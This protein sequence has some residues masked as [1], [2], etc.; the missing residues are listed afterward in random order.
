MPPLA[1][2]DSEL[3]AVLAAA[4]PLAVELRDPF[5]RA[6]AHELAGCGGEIGPGVVA[7][8]CRELQREFFD[9]PDLSR[10]AGSSKWR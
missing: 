8:T 4:R 7:R 9:P 10:T 5:L 6:V 1:L 3:D 2:S